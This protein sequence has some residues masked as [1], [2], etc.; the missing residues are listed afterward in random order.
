MNMNQNRNT[1]TN[2]NKHQLMKKIYEFGL[3]AYDTVLFLDTHPCDAEALAFYQKMKH[4]YNQAVKEYSALY[5]P[6]KINQIDNDQYWSW[7]EG[8]WP[9]EMGAC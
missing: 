9:W 5:G 2:Q 3:A 1:N 8:P 6:L 4:I 7:G